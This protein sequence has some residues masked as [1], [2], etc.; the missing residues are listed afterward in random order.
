MCCYAVRL[1]TRAGYDDALDVV[2]V[3][4]VGGLVGSLMIGL[5]ANP[6]FFEGDFL[7]GLVHGGGMRLLFVQAL[8]NAAAIGWSFPVTVGIMLALKATV[9]VRVDDEAE[10]LGLD[11]ILHGEAAYVDTAA[12]L[13]G[14][15]V[16]PWEDFD[17]STRPGE[18][19]AAAI[20]P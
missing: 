8:A 6:E 4:L 17:A 19:S 1:K 14:G 11:S 20:H 3:H 18:A 13:A 10:A 2:G 16:S 7:A 12:V 15:W 5:F 9:G